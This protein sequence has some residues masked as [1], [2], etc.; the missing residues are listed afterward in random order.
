MTAKQI[1]N[2]HAE[3]ITRDRTASDCDYAIYF[4][5]DN[6]ES[7]VLLEN[8]LDAWDFIEEAMK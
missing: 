7:W 8:T 1:M 6:A 4:V 2:D 5:T 3:W